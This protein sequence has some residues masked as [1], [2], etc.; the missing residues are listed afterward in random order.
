MKHST[1]W[2]CV[3]CAAC[4]MPRSAAAQPLSTRQIKT[5]Q[6]IKGLLERA[7]TLIEE[8]KFADAISAAN[9]AI[10]LSPK[11]ARAYR[12][13]GK[14]KLLQEFA[15]P[16]HFQFTYNLAFKQGTVSAP[17]TTESD[18]ATPT[19]W[20]GAADFSKAIE[21]APDDNQARL[22]LAR[23]LTHFGQWKTALRQYDDL[24]ENRVKDKAELAEVWYQRAICSQ[25]LKGAEAGIHDYDQ[26][27]ALQPKNVKYIGGRAYAY[28]QCG[29]IS[30]AIAEL[31][32]ALTI[33]D[34]DA[35]NY[36]YR[37]TLYSRRG[38]YKKAYADN[39]RV[40]KLNAGEKLTI[41][42][43]NNAAHALLR[44]R[45]FKKA[46]DHLTRA[47]ELINLKRPHVPLLRRKWACGAFQNR[48]IAQLN[49]KR[50]KA[51]LR[52]VNRAF[53]FAT[54]P[55]DELFAYR[56]RH[57]IYKRL[58]KHDLAGA[59]LAASKWI[60]RLL[61]LQSAV[62]AAPRNPQVLITLAEHYSA[63]DETPPGFVDVDRAIKLYGKA[64][65][66]APKS[67]AAYKRRARLLMQQGEL[68]DA[69]ADC[70]AVLRLEPAATEISLLRGEAYFQLKRYDA[71]IRD[72]ERGRAFGPHFAEAYL[73]RA[74][75][76]EK[77]GR[78]K[79][80]AADRRRAAA[81]TKANTPVRQTALPFPK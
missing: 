14:A 34:T 71:A 56:V 4:F 36:S 81:V 53:L 70:D 77:A 75:A 78:K 65:T 19:K 40:L 58:G 54:Q 42:A 11:H 2:N 69:I 72:F 67:A 49:L 21:L 6:K 74:R 17:A 26:A 28:G 45:D 48:A 3:L 23:C 22:L 29:K 24:I 76:H 51:A 64:I 43:H 55:G 46:C 31:T 5:A 73:A 63:T 32:R 30:K 57:A 33:D 68:K 61:L 41:A 1:V 18:S 12:L 10:R 25:A 80:A 39:V 27:I 79:Q 37:G 50:P 7:E 38:Q 20:R 44:L 35:T 9:E 66:A 13:R 60:T 62:K 47:I 15:D 59:D 8:E 16:T 52:D